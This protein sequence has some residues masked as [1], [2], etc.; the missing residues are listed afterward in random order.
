[1]PVNSPVNA[2]VARLGAPYWS[3]LETRGVYNHHFQVDRLVAANADVGVDTNLDWE[4]AG[5]SA[6]AAFNALGTQRLTT[7]AAG[8]A[9]AS[10]FPHQDSGQTLLNVID[11]DLSDGAVFDFLIAKPT[12]LAAVAIFAGFKLSTTLDLTT[13]ANQVVFYSNNG[14]NWQAATS[15]GGTDAQTNLGVAPTVDSPIRLS[16]LT[17]ADN[18]GDFYVNGTKVGSNIALPSTGAL[19][20]IV[21]IVGN[22]Q[23]LDIYG[24]RVAINRR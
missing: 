16:L 10:I 11:F 7:N 12:S 19:K 15:I 17:K 3:N 1:M 22:A 21:G 14:G 9:E 2:G 20:P 6:A 24:G 13:D 23:T 8:G 4:L 18:T 5:T